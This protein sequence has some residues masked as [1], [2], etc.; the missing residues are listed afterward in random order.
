MA[1]KKSTCELCGRSPVD[2]TVHHLI[3]RE[4]GGSHGP[5][6]ALCRTC[7]KQIHALYSNKELAIRLYTIKL[8]QEDEKINKYIKWVR[9]QPSE[10][11]LR[12]RKSKERRGK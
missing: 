10:T 4:E 1:V 8:L 12:V 9:K 5:T 3:P 11:I 2:T 7:H 6:A